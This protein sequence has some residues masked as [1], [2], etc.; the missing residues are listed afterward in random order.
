VRL[1]PLGSDKIGVGHAEGLEDVLA[2]VAVQGLPA[3]VLDDL[4]ERGKPVVGVHEPGARLCV[5]A[6]AALVVLVQ[7]RHRP[8]EFYGLDQVSQPEQARGV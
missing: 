2:H 8:S 6:E 5:D 7:G 4:T 1:D 3:H